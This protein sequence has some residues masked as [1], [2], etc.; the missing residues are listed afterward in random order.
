MLKKAKFM[1]LRWA[2]CLCATLLYRENKQK[3]KENHRLPTS[4]QT[5]SFTYLC[6]KL[7]AYCLGGYG[8]W[9]FDGFG[10]LG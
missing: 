4:K 1:I 2:R 8:Y 5:S 10:F 9:K 7:T 3:K 6:C